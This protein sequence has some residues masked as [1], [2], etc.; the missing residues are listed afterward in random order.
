[1]PGVPCNVKL[2]EN[3]TEFIDII[4]VKTLNK[5]SLIAKCW[6]QLEAFDL[7][8][9]IVASFVFCKRF[10]SLNRKAS[11]T[12]QSDGCQNMLDSRSFD[13]L[14]VCEVSA[15]QPFLSCGSNATAP[16]KWGVGL[17]PRGGSSFSVTSPAKQTTDFRWVHTQAR[18]QKGRVLSAILE[19]CWTVNLG[20]HG[21]PLCGMKQRLNSGRRNGSANP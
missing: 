15:H 2:S 3:L 7:Y 11:C 8:F 12:R 5:W 16:R 21:L 4:N 6:P 19:C 10:S 13:H 1:M 18:W 17:Y 20:F 14:V 9:R